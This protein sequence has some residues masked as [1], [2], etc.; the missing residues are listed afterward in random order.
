MA[1]RSQRGRRYWGGSLPFPRPRRPPHSLARSLVY[2][3]ARRAPAAPP[4]RRHLPR[5]NHRRSNQPIRRLGALGPPN[6]REARPRSA[7]TR[8]ASSGPPAAS[9]SRPLP[10]EHN[11]LKF[12]GHCNDIDQDMRKCLK[13]EYEANRAKSKAHAEV[14]RQRQ[15]RTES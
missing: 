4:A 5:A 10:G 15:R 8:D 6:Q 14:M 2:S 3:P 12:F 13:K 11:F 7:V 9:G 1:L